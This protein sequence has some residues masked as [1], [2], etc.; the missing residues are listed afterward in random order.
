MFARPQIFESRSIALRKVF[1]HDDISEA[2]MAS[3]W[4]LVLRDSIKW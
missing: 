4:S 2:T 3:L 1:T